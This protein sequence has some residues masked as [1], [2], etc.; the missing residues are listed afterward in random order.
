M[1][2]AIPCI[3]NRVE[4]Q[5][6]GIKGMEKNEEVVHEG[7]KCEGCGIETI[8]GVRYS[9]PKCELFNLCEAC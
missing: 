7:I 5:M 2:N 6:K 8:T 4:I 9:C 3:A 1:S